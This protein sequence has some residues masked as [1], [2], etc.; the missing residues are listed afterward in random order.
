MCTNITSWENLFQVF[1]KR[2]IDGKSIL[3]AA[4]DRTFLDHQDPSILFEDCRLNLS[5]L[6][7]DKPTNIDACSV[8]LKH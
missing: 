5:D 2:R 4:M 3:E 7:I 1:E 8:R 6:L